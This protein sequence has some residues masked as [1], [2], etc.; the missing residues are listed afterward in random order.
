M[1]KNSFFI[2]IFTF[3]VCT[4]ANTWTNPITIWPFASGLKLSSSCEK[5]I[6]ENIQNQRNLY[7]YPVMGSLKN[8]EY[9]KGVSYFNGLTAHK[10]K[11]R[12]FV[13]KGASIIFSADILVPTGQCNHK[14]EYWRGELDSSKECKIISLEHEL[15]YTNYHGCSG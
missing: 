9:L 2:F 6:N 13:Y 1:L 11:L 4:Y 3:A 14:F 10:I 12:G 15:D 7:R 8:N 5:K